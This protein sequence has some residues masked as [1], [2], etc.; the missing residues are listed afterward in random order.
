METPAD[1]P[2]RRGRLAGPEHHP[3]TGELLPGRSHLDRLQRRS[4]QSQ[5]LDRCLSRRRD[6]R[7]DRLDPLELRQRHTHSG[8]RTPGG[9]HDLRLGTQSGRHLD[10]LPPGQRRVHRGDQRLLQ[11]HRAHRPGRPPIAQSLRSG[12]ADH[13]GLHQWSRQPQGLDRH[14]QSRSGPGIGGIDA[15]AV[16]RRN[17]LGHLGEVEWVRDLPRRTDGRGAVPGLSARKRRVHLTGQ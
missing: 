12:R 6:A 10:R 11:R 13:R 9:R 17:D 16:P 7:L 4:R 3:V 5:G 2:R 14:L 1:R 15:V 8:G